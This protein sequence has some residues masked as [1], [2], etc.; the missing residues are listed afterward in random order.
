LQYWFFYPFNDWRSEFYGANDHE[1]D[2]EKIFV[3]LSES[4]TGEVQPE[5]AAYAAHN[6]AGDDLRRRW[7]DPELEK[8]GEHP[9]IY[10]GA[11]SHASYYVQGEYLTEL[12]LRPPGPIAKATGAFRSFW[13]KTLRQYSGDETRLEQNGVTNLFLIPFVDYARGDGVV[14]GPG[15]DKEW[16]PPRL[17]DSP[18]AEWVPGYRGLWGFYARDPFEGEDAPSGPMYNHDKSVRREWYDPVGW[19]GLDKVPTQTEVMR[20]ILDQRS[21]V[22]D[23]AA[24]LR[25]EIEKKSLKLKKL[26]VEVAAMRDRSHLSGPY[27]AQKMRLDELSQEV[28]EL[29]AQLA[30]DRIVSESL[31]DY[32]A[33]LRDGEREPA[34]AHISRPLQPASDQARRTGRLTEVWGAVSVGLMLIILVA[35]VVFKRDEPT[36]ALVV[37]IA[38]FAFLEASFRGRLTNLVSSVNVGLGVVAALIIVY[39]F[40]WG[41]V[42]V[43]VLIVGIYILW[44]NLRELRR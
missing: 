31:E 30:T 34:R 41:L 11:G 21:D 2:W 20:A 13:R 17:L 15:Q 29:R 32:A 40:F 12:E 16:E 18:S 38:L 1:G 3:Y 8:V 10:V 28:E 4:E 43:A 27:R 44:D 19:A 35:I 25:E 37:S 22:A 42:A 33:Q 6:Y 5:W 24:T 9:V 36:Y 26:G 39:E 14:V 23:R 7:D